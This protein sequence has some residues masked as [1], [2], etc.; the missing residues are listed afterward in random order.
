MQTRKTS[1]TA[2]AD[3]VAQLTQSKIFDE[4]TPINGKFY[5]EAEVFLKEAN[6]LMEQ[7]SLTLKPNSHE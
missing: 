4:T 2:L 6:Q 3:Q 5:E 7:I 1:Y